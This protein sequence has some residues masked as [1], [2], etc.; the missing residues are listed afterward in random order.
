MF[1]HRI[2]DDLELRLLEERHAQELFALIDRDRD[3][4]RT[5]LPWVDASRSADDT[6]AFIRATRQEFAAGRDLPLGIWHHGRPVGT[7]ELRVNPADRAGEIG[8]WLARDAR[9]QGIVTRA[10]RALL[11]YA[12]GELAL[13]RVVIRCATGNH[14]SR[15]IPERLG[16][17]LEGTL[18]QAQWV[19]DHFNDLAVYA[20]LR[21]GWDRVS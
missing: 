19:N 15:A 11:A 5:W 6:A 9:G 20:M 18:R 8:Y 21:P 1:A 7:I 13:H 17:A 2:D 10:V 4:L 12:F 14:P 16:F 3:D